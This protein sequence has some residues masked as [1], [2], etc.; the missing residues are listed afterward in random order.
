[1]VGYYEHTFREVYAFKCVGG[2]GEG[3]VPMD[4]H[5]LEV[6]TVG[7]GVVADARC[8]A[9]ACC[10]DDGAGRCGY[11]GAHRGGDVDGGEGGV[12]AEGV[13]LSKVKLLVPNTALPAYKSADIWND[14]GEIIGFDPDGIAPVSTVKGSAPQRYNLSG[15]QV[16]APHHGIVIA[17]GHKVL[18]KK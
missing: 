14:F 3:T 15:Q 16:A 8:R 7:E 17:N 10:C 18:Y 2:N 5:L 12:V 6:G 4:C 9:A 1:M 11:G 13:D